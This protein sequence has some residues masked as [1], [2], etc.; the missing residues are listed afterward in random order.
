MYGAL[1]KELWWWSGKDRDLREP[2][3]HL[4][5]GEQEKGRLGPSFLAGLG[6]NFTLPNNR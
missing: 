5:Y 6:E 1:C 2:H 4:E 3:G